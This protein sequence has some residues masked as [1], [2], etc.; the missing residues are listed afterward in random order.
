M[1]L[2][3]DIVS[4]GTCECLYH[5]HKD[6]KHCYHRRY[7]RVYNPIEG[8]HYRISVC[9][10]AFRLHFN[11]LYFGR[12]ND[13]ARFFTY[14]ISKYILSILDIPSAYEKY[15]AKPAH[16]LPHIHITICNKPYTYI[17]VSFKDVVQWY[18][19]N[20]NYWLQDKLILAVREFLQ[21]K[22][23]VKKY[24]SACNAIKS[25]LRKLSCAYN[26]ENEIII[27]EILLLILK[28]I[29][30]E[31]YK[32][33]VPSTL[34]VRPNGKTRQARSN[35]GRSKSTSTLSEASQQCAEV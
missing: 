4:H 5:S 32:Q 22:E 8:N 18:L 21:Q 14:D 24:V 16:H 26:E 27:N 19:N 31:T 17:T 30:N 15:P 28:V 25:L 10:E 11:Q 34:P 2:Y 7:F 1:N 35:S 6:I 23:R 33:Q 13:F 9:K 29:Y 20:K 3:E 12:E